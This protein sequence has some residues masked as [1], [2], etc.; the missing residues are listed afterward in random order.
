[1]KTLKLISIIIPLVL[2]LCFITGCQNQAAKAELEEMKA[3][4]E[5]EEQNKALFLKLYEE[6]DKGNVGILDEVAS[7][8]LRFYGPGSFEPITI[9]DFKPIYDLWYG[10]F[11]DYIHTIEDIIAEGD[12]VAVRITYTGIHEGE[13]M[14]T[15]PT[16]K[17][18]KYCGIHIGKVKDGK[19]VEVWI[20]EDMLWL[21]Q[22]L[23]MELKPKE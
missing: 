6:F 3:Q 23:G 13:F 4:A 12:T 22:Q 5:V 9:S 17:P 14:G 10:A 18:F 19:I 21:M 16:G 1:M 7:P 20:M 11:R 8:D 15:Q 2:V